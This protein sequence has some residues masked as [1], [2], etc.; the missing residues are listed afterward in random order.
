MLL[1]LFST[2][3][4]DFWSLQLVRPSLSDFKR[5]ARRMVREAKFHELRTSPIEGLAFLQTQVCTVCL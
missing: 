2:R 3:L 5:G 1:L 4:G